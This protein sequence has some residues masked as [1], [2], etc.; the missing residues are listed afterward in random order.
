MISKLP[1]RGHL[2]RPADEEGRALAVHYLRAGRL[3]AVPT[4]T[5]YG[6][7]S[8]GLLPSAILRLFRA[9]DRPRERAIPA[10]IGEPEHLN[11]VADDPPPEALA[12][13]E[14]FWPG[15][16]TLVLRKKEHIPAEL[17]AGGDSVAVRLPDHP[18]PRD[19]CRALGAPLATTSANRSGE[20]EAR[21]ADE[22]EASLGR[23][24]HLI[25][26]AGS[27]P[28]GTPSTVVDL[29]GDVPRLLRQGP[30]PRDAVAELLPDLKLG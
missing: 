26:D 18:V 5:V 16:L 22:V 14:R 30:V 19:L 6:V 15:G 8:H 7:A 1:S 2:I 20:P 21:A 25:L 3:V 9:K 27:S 12:L 13:A 11:W 23:H 4:D 24:L 10:L 29:T 28:G 17:T